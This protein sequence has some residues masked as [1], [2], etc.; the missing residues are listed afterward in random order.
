MPQVSVGRLYIYHNCFARTKATRVS[1]SIS[2]LEPAQCLLSGTS[3]YTLLQ[4]VWLVELTLIK[5]TTLLTVRVSVCTTYSLYYW[6][7][8]CPTI[9][10][11]THDPM[12]MKSIEMQ[13]L[14]IQQ[15][16][17]IEHKKVA[18]GKCISAIQAKMI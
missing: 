4:L 2:S 15:K 6:V 3:I 16:R 12:N 5:V 9:R 8:H 11:V 7:S 13:R 10:I 18:L 14:A 17:A 1:E